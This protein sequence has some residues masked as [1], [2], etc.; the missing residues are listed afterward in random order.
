MP[1]RLGLEGEE[2]PRVIHYY[3]EPYAYTG[4]RVAVV[5]GKNSAVKAALDCYRN[6]AEVTVIHRGEQL[7]PSVKYWLR[8]DIDNRIK[9]GSIR[10]FFRSRITSIEDGQL[11]LATPDGEQTIGNDFVLAMTGYRPDYRLCEQL[12]LDV[13]D[14]PARTP[15]HD[16]QSFES[17][18]PCMMTRLN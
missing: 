15:S 2:P 17:S 6:G 14:D 10:A 18:R 3:K 9:E 4:Q 13:D 1:N 16:D 5:G 7:A 8:P 12:G 11:R